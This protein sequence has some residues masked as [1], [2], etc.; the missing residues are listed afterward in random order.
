MHNLYMISVG[1]KY[2]INA[3]IAQL[4]HTVSLDKIYKTLEK[5]HSITPEQFDRDRMIN[6]ESEEVIPAFRLMI[7]SRVLAI[8]F[9]D[10]LAK[11]TI[12][13]SD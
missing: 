3:H 1:L 2:S 10:L 4:S 5:H 11:Q 6:A 13:N 12:K 8:P 9:E 7:Y